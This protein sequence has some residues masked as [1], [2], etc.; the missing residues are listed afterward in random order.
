MRSQTHTPAPQPTDQEPQGRTLT[1]AGHLEELRRRLGI[2]L[3]AVVVA[4]GVSC[5]QLERLI[6]WLLRPARPHLS[7][8]AFFSPTEP[9]LAYLAVAT[10]S[11][12]VLAMPVLLW[13]LWDFVRPGLTRRERV[14]GLAFVLSGSALFIGGVAFAY[15]VLLP[16]SLGFLLGIAHDT[17][18]P[19]ISIQRYLAFVTSL[20]VLC[21]LVFE[22]P[23]VL[24]GLAKIGVVTPEWLRQQRPSAILV[25]V[26]IAAVVTPTTDVASLLLLTIPLVLLYELSILLA[27]LSKRFG[28]R[29]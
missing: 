14:W 22:L 20:A 6:D 2:S 11:G 1:L 24:F 27:W 18:E 23:A 10:L 21:G 25:L 16:L 29:A 28:S 17:L 4:I 3:A 13:Q 15:A 26:S 7:H 12:F 19:V 9:L 8:L 5:T